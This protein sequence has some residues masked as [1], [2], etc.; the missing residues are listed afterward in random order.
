MDWVT[1][2]FM[3]IAFCAGFF[4]HVLMDALMW[5]KL[6]KKLEQMGGAKCE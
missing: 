4:G 6:E 3:L 5:E 1:I 2:I